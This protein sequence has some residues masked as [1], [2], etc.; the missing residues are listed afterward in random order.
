MAGQALGAPLAG[1]GPQPVHQDLDPAEGVPT[2]GLANCHAALI[3][4]RQRGQHHRS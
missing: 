4:G 2:A 3:E 1:W